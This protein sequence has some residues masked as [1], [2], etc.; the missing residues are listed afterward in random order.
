MDRP[1]DPWI[2]SLSCYP[3]QCWRYKVKSLSHEIL[4]TMTCKQYEVICSVRTN[5]YLK[6]DRY[7]LKS[8]EDMSESLNHERYV[9]VTYK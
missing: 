8:A 1:G 6:Y 2:D 9:I 4:I 5:H 3:L 7:L